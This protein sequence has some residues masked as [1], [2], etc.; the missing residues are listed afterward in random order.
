MSQKVR[1]R[2]LMVDGVAYLWRVSHK[3]GTESFAA[4]R[5]NHPRA[6]L[7]VLFTAGPKG[8]QEY[9]ERAG[10]IVA[11]GSDA[12]AVNLN[13]PRT[14]AALIRHALTAG[15]SPEQ[16]VQMHVEDGF[17]FLASLPAEV[18]ASLDE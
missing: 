10:V 9:I 12:G 5:R 2:T 4:Y 3:I 17:E 6:P 16:D 11:Y 8:G 18:R 13:R 15:W 1:A 14:A 7:R